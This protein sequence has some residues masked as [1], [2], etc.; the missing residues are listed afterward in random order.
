M[1]T[2]YLA[3]PIHHVSPEQAMGWRKKATEILK[4]WGYEILDPT[5]GKDLYDP[6]VNTRTYTPR[7]IVETDIG[8]INKAD[9]LLVDISHLVPCWGTAMEIRHA[10]TKG[11][12]IITFGAANKESYWIRYHATSMYG[13]LDEALY[14]LKYL[15]DYLKKMEGNQ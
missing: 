7:H 12:T 13:R 6:N 15:A 3:G 1:R 10:W 2:V 8:M 14:Y 4:P 9:I 5:A 11:K